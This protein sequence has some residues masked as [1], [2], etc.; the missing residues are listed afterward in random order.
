MEYE[1]DVDYEGGD[2]DDPNSDEET[3]DNAVN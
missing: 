3:D 2:D 1:R